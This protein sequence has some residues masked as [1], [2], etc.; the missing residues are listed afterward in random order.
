MMGLDTVKND[1]NMRF[2]VYLVFVQTHPI[3]SVYIYH[4]HLTPS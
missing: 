4:T 2:L 1:K 3:S